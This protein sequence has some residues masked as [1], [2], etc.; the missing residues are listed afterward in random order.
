MLQ[1]QM[2]SELNIFDASGSNVNG[3]SKE[4]VI[5]AA[6]ESYTGAHHV[7]DVILTEDK[8]GI[9]TLFP[10][11]DVGLWAQ[12]KGEIRPAGKNAYKVW[13]P[14]LLKRTLKDLGATFDGHLVSI[15]ASELK[16]ARPRGGVGLSRYKISPLFFVRKAN[17]T[18]NGAACEFRIEDIEQLNPTIAAHMFF[19]T[20]RY[21]D[22][23]T[24]YL[25]KE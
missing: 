25:E 11:Q 19:K 15:N 6:S 9:L 4:S 21:Q 14:K 24:H 13:T 5:R 12:L 10:S 18:I 23:K 20:L 17:V 3:F 1:E 8:Q 16:T 22:A 2:D 7:A